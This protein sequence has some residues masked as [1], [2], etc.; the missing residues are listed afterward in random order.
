[1]NETMKEERREENRTTTAPIKKNLL[2]RMPKVQTVT[3][4]LKSNNLFKYKDKLTTSLFGLSTKRAL[5][6]PGRVKNHDSSKA[7]A[8]LSHTRTHKRT[9]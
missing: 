5:H 4:S 9:E 1:M 3:K 7:V 6:K 8:T 2:Q